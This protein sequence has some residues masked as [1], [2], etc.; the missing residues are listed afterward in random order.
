V[1]SK[2][3]LNFA[4]LL[5][6]VANREEIMITK[7]GRPV[8]KLIPVAGASHERIRVTI[9]RLKEFCQGQTLGGLSMR[10]LRE[11]GRR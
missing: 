9:A 10:E 2:R 5:E 6:R 11:D 4:S 3:R 1:R 8:A 7:H